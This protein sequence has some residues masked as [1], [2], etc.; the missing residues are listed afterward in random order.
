VAL[1]GADRADTCSARRAPGAWVARFRAHV[2][3]LVQTLMDGLA[4]GGLYALVALG[5]TMVYGI[6]KFINFAHSDVFVLG[7]WL[8]F[9]VAVHLLGLGLSSAGAG[10]APWWAL[11]AVL[12]SAMAACGLAGFLIERFAYRPLRNAPRLNVLITAI[13]VSLLLQNT[14]QLRVFFGPY[15]KRMP[16]LVPD[17]ALGQIAG[18][19][20]PLVDVL[21]IATALLLML[22]LEWL[23]FRTKLGRA[24][25]AVSYNT[26]IAALMGVNVNRVISFTFVLGSALA[27]AA[28]LL[29][30]LK[31]PAGL[32][33]P[34]DTSWVMMGL[35]AFVAAVVGGIGNVRGAML[36]GLLIGLLEFFG[37]AY[38]DPLYRDVYVFSLLILVLLFRP[39]GILGRPATEKV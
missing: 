29:Y 37:V 5:Y 17:V 1:H 36:G 23:I 8:S 16:T 33:Q 38:F 6:L 15:P 31:Y 21:V 18:V 9:T 7:A 26:S 32:K 12:V 19:R 39:T 13:G 35:K 34:A 30:G 25:R 22:A 14:G 20:I 2:T 27:A 3:K 24:M 28:G 4:A 11:P 10:A